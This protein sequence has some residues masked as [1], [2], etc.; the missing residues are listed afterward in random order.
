[1]QIVVD[2]L[3]NRFVHLSKSANLSYLVAGQ[4]KS[5]NYYDIAHIYLGAT[6]DPWIRSI[7]TE[8]QKS[9]W[10]N[11]RHKY[12][13]FIGV[14]R[15]Q[16]FSLLCTKWRNKYASMLQIN[17]ISIPCND[18]TCPCHCVSAF[19]LVNC[20]HCHSNHEMKSALSPDKWVLSVLVG[21][22]I[23][24]MQSVTKWGT[25]QYVGICSFL[26]IPPSK[27]VLSICNSS[28]PYEW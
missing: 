6:G 14:T 8:A 16:P 24:T 18:R 7:L 10:C 27:Y 12:E 23:M 21:M 17:F 11:N 13:F 22:E 19:G 4:R 26:N 15:L 2:F 20:R 28:I 9:G 5:R 25:N 3:T 1:M